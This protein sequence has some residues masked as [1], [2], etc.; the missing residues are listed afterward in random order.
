[1]LAAA[2]VDDWESAAGEFV[3]L[4]EQALD[5]GAL[6]HARLGY[7]M[8]SYVQWM[9]GR[10]SGAREETLQAERVSRG[11]SEEDQIIGM[12]ETAKCLAMLERDL[13]QADALLMEASALAVRKRLRHP[14]IPMALG[15]LRFHEN[16]L[17][18]AEELLK[19]ARTLCKSAGDRVNEFM[20]NEYLAM[21]D[22]ER[23]GFEAALGRCATLIDIGGKLREGSEAPFARALEALCLYALKDDAGPLE[24]ALAE[25][26]IADAKHRL[27]Y[28]LN[29]AA[30]LDAERGRPEDALARAGEA[31]EHAEALERYTEMTLAHFA[32]ARACQACGDDEGFDRHAA[33][34]AALDG[35]SVAR[36]ARKR[37][38]LLA[39]LHG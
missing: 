32:L 14:A 21:I 23:D 13:S 26:R 25:L 12:A 5:Y 37:T 9:H 28:T 19:E 1:M 10:W 6:T 16:K 27:A 20:A 11:S 34:V 36:W 39:V 8:A 24:E 17:D 3:E 31:L 2:P 4:A 15:L 30:L 7:Q 33:V 29:R 18:E 22:I 35:A 38:E